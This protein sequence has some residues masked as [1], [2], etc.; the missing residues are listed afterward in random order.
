[1]R[2]LNDSAGQP[3]QAALLD[4]SCGSIHLVFSPLGEP[5]LRRHPAQAATRAKAA[6]WFEGMDDDA[7]RAL[8]ETAEPWDPANGN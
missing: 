4:A 5:G 3:W 7:L 2:T 1:M 8:L 6:E